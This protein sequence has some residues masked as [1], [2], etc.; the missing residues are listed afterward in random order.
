M[1]MSLADF[2][3]GAQPARQSGQVAAPAD[4]V[5]GDEIFQ[6]VILIG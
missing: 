2:P 3:W 1:G 4:G 6:R 5:L